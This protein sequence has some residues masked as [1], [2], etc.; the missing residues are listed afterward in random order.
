MADNIFLSPFKEYL[1][2]DVTNEEQDAVLNICLNSAQQ[3]IETSIGI[4]IGN[5]DETL[6]LNGNGFSFIQSDVWPLTV[7]SSITIGDT[8]QDISN[9]YFDGYEIGLLTGVFTS[10]TRN[11]EVE[12]SVGYTDTN[13]PA[14]LLMALFKLAEKQFIDAT[15]NREGISL[16]SNDIKQRVSYT[17]KLPP[18]VVQVFNS[19][20]PFRF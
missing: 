2:R 3:F 9:Y 4:V 6:L 13:I 10:G 1:E 17:N 12:V 19:Y 16:L 8:L 18:F 20:R 14:D 15:D 11:V 7:I 5:R